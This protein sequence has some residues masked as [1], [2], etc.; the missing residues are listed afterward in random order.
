MA[1]IEIPMTLGYTS[2]DWSGLPAYPPYNLPDPVINGGG[3]KFD[4]SPPLLDNSDSTYVEISW[5][6]G[7]QPSINRGMFT[8]GGDP[9]SEYKAGWPNRPTTR[10]AFDGTIYGDRY[11]QETYRLECEYP[12]TGKAIE[13]G[14]RAA[15]FDV[16]NP[17]PQGYY[18]SP[19]KLYL[20]GLPTE[21]EIDDI[22]GITYIRRSVEVPLTRFDG[23]FRDYIYTEDVETAVAPGVIR[24]RPNALFTPPEGYAGEYRFGV[25]IAK[26]YLKVVTPSI[27][28]SIGPLRSRFNGG[29]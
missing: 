4:A 18:F 23:V 22:D 29:R 28:G 8:Q 19:P 9:D 16:G 5:A 27:E 11:A 20:N 24:F 25:R 6:T 7:A 15:F 1:V 13:M 12:P 2:A 3:T 14:M 21:P 10:R 26:V 17:P